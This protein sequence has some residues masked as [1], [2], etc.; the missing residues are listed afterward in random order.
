MC[1]KCNPYQWYV[2]VCNKVDQFHVTQRAELVVGRV[3]P[4]HATSQVFLCQKPLFYMGVDTLCL[5]LGEI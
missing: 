1:N 2:T 3:G 5:K 4:V